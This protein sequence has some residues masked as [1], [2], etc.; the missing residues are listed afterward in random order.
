MLCPGIVDTG[1]RRIIFWIERLRVAIEALSRLVLRLEPEMTEEIFKKALEWYRNDYIAQDSWMSQPVRHLLERSFDAL[2]ESRRTELALDLLGAP[3]V[4]LDN[5]VT[6]VSHYPDPG[7]LLEK[8][9]P[10]PIR[11]SDNENSWQETINF[12]VRGLRAGDEARKRASRRIVE[13]AVWERLMDSETLQVAQALWNVDYIE[14]NDLPSGTDLCD[15]EFFLLPEPESGIAEQRFRRK[16]LN[17]NSLSQE[18]APNLDEILWHV[19][20]AI[21]E[22]NKHQRS[23]ELSEEEEDYL[24]KIIK[25]WSDTPMPIPIHPF[26]TERSKSTHRAIIG[27]QSILL[28]IQ[29]PKSIAEQ[30]YKKVKAKDLYEPEQLTLGEM[31]ERQ[32]ANYEEVKALNESDMPCNE[33]VAGIVKSWPDCF[34]D[35]ATLM[36]ISL[37]SG[38]R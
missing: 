25:Q 29:V 31:R 26:D 34:D 30:L 19:G 37:V 8:E 35:M 7:Y 18:N 23:L 4:G 9:F 3:I 5:F 12:L 6:D 21:S 14:S 28:E 17:T 13:I 24:V 27:L 11:A 10:P 36:R 38:K 33:L 16:W 22:L 1:R 20:D 32:Q 15:W 2:P